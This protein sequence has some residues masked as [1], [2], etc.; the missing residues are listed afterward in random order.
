MD[1]RFSA[2]DE[3]FRQEVV[4]FLEAEIPADWADTPEGVAEDGATDKARWDFTRDFSRKLGDRGWRWL[5]W[6]SGSR[7]TCRDSRCSLREHYVMFAER[8]TT[9]SARQP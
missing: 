1:F 4:D 2:E 9:I 8:T 6:P 7:L 3:A 5:G